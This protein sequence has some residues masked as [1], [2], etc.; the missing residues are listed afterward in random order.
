MVAATWRVANDTFVFGYGL[1][2][3]QQVNGP[4]AA[5]VRPRPAEVIKDRLIGAAGVFQG[6]GQDWV[7]LEGPAVVDGLSKAASSE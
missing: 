6:V 3:E 1:L 5:D 7:T 2:C 4:T